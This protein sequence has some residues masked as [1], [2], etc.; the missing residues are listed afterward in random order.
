MFADRADSLAR[1]EFVAVSIAA[2]WM[3]GCSRRGSYFGAFVPPRTQSLVYLLGAE[4]ETLDPGLTTPSFESFIIPT[5]FEGL[6]TAHPQDCTPMAGVATHFTASTDN[7]RFVFFLRGHPRPLGI[8]LPNTDTLGAEFKSGHCRQDFS[9]GL[10]APPDRLPARWSDGHP[11]TAHD[12]VYAW[13]RVVDPR[14]AASYA[15][16]LYYVFNGEEI[17]LGRRRIEDLGVEARGDF[18]LAVTVRAPMPFLL[19]QISHRVF[20][21]V[22]AHV[23]DAARLL[24]NEVRWTDAENIV[25]NG[26]FRLERWSAY[27][28][29]VVRKNPSYWEAGLVGLDE[30]RF[31]PTADG[32]VGT[33]L[34][35]ANKAYSMPGE[36]LPQVF[37]PLLTGMKDFHTGPA[38]FTVYHG[39][40][41]RL[42]PF[43]NL[44]VRYA[45]NMSLDKDRIAEVLGAGRKPARNLIPPLPWYPRLER[46]DV[47]IGGATCDVLAYSP[48]TA[49]DLLAKAGFSQRSLRVELSF[50]NLPHSRLVAEMLQHQWRVELDAKV[51]LAMLEYKEWIA[52]NSSLKYRGLTEIGWWANYLDP[53]TFLDLFTT[54]SSHNWTGWI[55]P[56]FDQSLIA[57]NAAPSVL[58]RTKLLLD[59]ERQLLQAMP[60]IPLFFNSWAYLQKPFVR[61]IEQNPLDVHPF[62]YAWIDTNG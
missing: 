29:I 6:V 2:G 58:A 12:F 50:P 32:T 53:N 7:S 14:S 23:I 4:P 31:W 38:F 41:T 33:N 15:S 36:R 42:P 39:F 62:K 8:R 22:P 20:A 49:R 27:D 13:R 28:E 61:G 51:D 60:I 3:L 37:P 48:Q 44:W 52:V 18:E 57:A 35:K 47:D 59:C 43:D 21:P 5:M 16:Y 34:Y 17:N 19:Q 11:V 45:F 54:G 24:G 56:Q 10:T 9:R 1:R 40:N 55:D 46:M 30:V 25:V 26:P